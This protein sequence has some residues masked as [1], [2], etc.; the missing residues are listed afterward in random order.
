MK[1]RLRFLSHQVRRRDQ[2]NGQR[3]QGR[4]D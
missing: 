2:T 3:P 1:L 4:V